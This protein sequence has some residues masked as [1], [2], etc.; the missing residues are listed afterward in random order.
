VEG[1]ALNGQFYLSVWLGLGDHREPL[2]QLGSLLERYPHPAVSDSY[3][4]ARMVSSLTDGQLAD[5]EQWI[6]VVGRQWRSHGRAAEAEIFVN[7]GMLQV[8][9]ER[10]GLAPLIPL[11]RAMPLQAGDPARP[12]V[13]GGLTAL[14][15]AEA[16]A[17]D[18][19]RA[20]IDEKSGKAFTDL[21][22]DYALP[23]AQ[24]AWAEAAA[25][26]G[27]RDACVAFEKRL[28]HQADMHQTTGG[29]YLG[30]TSRYLALLADA[31]GRDDDADARFAQ[32]VSEHIRMQSPTWLARTRLDWAEAR[33]RRG[34]DT[35]SR[36]LAQQALADIGDLELEASRSRAQRLLRQ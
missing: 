11:L 34:D 7:S 8:A 2:S 31:Q 5:A 21:A 13:L 10:M 29:W 32:A 22:D 6:Q 23:V 25:I 24:C 33:L 18:E 17:L 14:A 1:G 12:E 9:R 20:L 28:A 3:V 36:Q 19:A 27:H 16:G 35:K 15:L 4:L 26:T 30:A